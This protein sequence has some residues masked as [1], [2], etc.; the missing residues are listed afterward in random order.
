MKSEIRRVA[1][2][3]M[4]DN[5]GGIESVIINIYRHMDKTKVQL[6]FLLPHDYGEIAYE[7]EII[8][9]G[10][11]IFRI[12]YSERESLIKSR[13]CLLKF[14]REHPEVKVVHVHANFPYAFPL[15]IAK[16]AGVPIR[17]LHSH[18]S[19]ELFVGEPGI[20]GKIKNIRNSVVKKQINSVPNLYFSC[21]DLAAKSMFKDKDYVWVKNGIDL[22]KFDYD[23]Q[24]RNELR[25]EYNIKKND[26]VIG[27][28][29]RLREQKNPIFLIDIF[30]EYTKINDS[31]KLIV[32]GD[33]EL[34]TE[35]KSKIEYYGIEN[36]VRF[37]GSRNDVY[38]WY[39]VFDLLLLPSIYE[40]LPVVLVEGQAAGLPCIA[41]DAIT[42]Q[43]KVTDLLHYK[44]IGMSP[45]EWA[46]DIHDILSKSNR[47]S[48]MDE[49]RKAGFDIKQAAEQVMQYYLNGTS[50]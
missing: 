9:M 25:R 28:V 35:M 11:R 50:D 2:W 19:T 13:T 27:F 43:I 33:G 42:K 10:G 30:N 32:I 4:S 41:S 20:K 6:D 31:T 5:K 26:K 1:I 48:Y 34:Q 15:V 40:G 49:M 47:R 16:K 36:K 46:N 23:E 38:K 3:G 14:F 18:N 44:S 17:I 24:I 8:A 7:D 22:K 29:G 21:S 39:Q 12:M 45:Q 37:L